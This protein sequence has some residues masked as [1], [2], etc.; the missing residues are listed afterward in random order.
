[1]QTL[2]ILLAPTLYAASIYMALG[3][4]ITSLKGEHLSYVPVRFMTKIFV[5][6]DVLSFVLQGAGTQD[7]TRPFNY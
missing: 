2:F 6:G 1:M 4:I 3:R 7:D 5:M